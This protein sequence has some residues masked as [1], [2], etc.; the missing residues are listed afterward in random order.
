MMMHI[1][2]CGGNTVTRH[3]RLHCNRSKLVRLSTAASTCSNTI[4]LFGIKGLVHP[5]D[6]KVLSHRVIERCNDLRARIK[7][8]TITSS[9]VCN[10]EAMKQS[11]ELLSLLDRVSNEVCSVIDAA[12][13]CRNV[14]TNDSYISAAS[15]AYSTLSSY[16]H[17][18]N[19]DTNL[20]GKLKSL[21]DNK[22]I[23]N[24]LSEGK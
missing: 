21:T 6:F 9:S 5:S 20:Y 7:L 2:K 12:E 15:D 18:L 14:H 16:I 19:G 22:D 17:I 11:Y 3:H 8:S 23:Y 10:D 13:L 24:K 1:R 4:G